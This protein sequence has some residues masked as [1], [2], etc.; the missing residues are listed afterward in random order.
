MFERLQNNKKLALLERY[1][2][3]L[4]YVFDSEEVEEAIKRNRTFNPF[5]LMTTAF[6]KISNSRL[7]KLNNAFQRNNY[8]RTL[9][10]SQIS[11]ILEKLVT[12]GLGE[13]GEKVH[14]DKLEKLL[15][16]CR[17]FAK[18]KRINK[19]PLTSRLS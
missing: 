17:E 5:P 4:G 12:Q 6:D 13:W 2:N 19:K 14:P 3:N 9:S 15:L 18:G 16:G 7:A 1:L 10:P 11:E 8:L